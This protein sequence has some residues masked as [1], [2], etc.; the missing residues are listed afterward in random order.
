ML[1]RDG[2]YKLIE[3]CL[4]ALNAER[5]PDEQIRVSPDTRLLA[6]GSGLDSLDVVSFSVD[7]EERIR[8]LTD[9]DLDI[10]PAALAEDEH[11]LR[12]VTTLTDFL[13]TK[14]SVPR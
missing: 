11:P 4:V 6:E 13:A 7:L 9:R 2:I 10:S 3:E 12:T 1:T 5:H 8:R 14:L